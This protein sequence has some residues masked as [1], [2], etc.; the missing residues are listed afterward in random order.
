MRTSDA[1]NL[2]PEEQRWLPWTGASGKLAMGWSCWL[3]RQR[4]DYYEHVFSQIAETRRAVLMEWAEQKWSFI[5]GVAQ[6]LVRQNST[7]A[8]HEMHKQR[9]R[10]REISELALINDQGV[11]LYS[12]HTARVGQH[13]LPPAAWQRGLRERFLHGPYHDPVTFQLGATTS[14]FHDAITLM[15][16]LPVTL[17]DGQQVAIL[18]RVPN[19]V[20]SDLIQREAGHVFEES[21]DNYLFMANSQFDPSIHS[22]VALSRSRFEDN[23]FSHGD[24]LKDGI[25]TGFGIVSVREHTEFE[26][27]FTDPAT[28]QLHPGV[29]ETLAAGENVYVKYPGYSDYRHIPVIGKGVTLQ[30]PGSPDRW[31]M[32]CEADLAEVY[33]RRSIRYH[34]S[35]R[36][37]LLAGIWWLM[38]VL[39]N[40]AA[41]PLLWSACVYGVGVFATLVVYH[42]W[43]AHPLAERLHGMADLV[44]GLADGGGNL[45]QRLSV[46]DMARDETGDLAR[47]LN[48]F[49][50]SLDRMVSNVSHLSQASGVASEQLLKENQQAEQRI[51]GV[52]QS[53]QTMLNGAQQQQQDIQQAS[54]TA[55]NLRQ[56]MDDVMTRAQQ[57]LTRVSNET[58]SIRS[59]IN[60]SSDSLQQANERTAEIA[61]MALVIKDIAAQ[62]NLLALNA[63]IEA[64]RAGDSGRGFAVVAS[65]V[66]NLASRTAQATQEID[67]GLSRVQEETE[68]AVSTME[69]GM[70][71]MEQR[72]QQAQAAASDHST[73]NDMV[74]NLFR[75]MAD[76]E[77]AN[78]QQSAQ[79]QEVAEGADSMQDT[80]A[81][82]IVSADTTH[83]NASKLQA[84]TRQFQLSKQY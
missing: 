22:G 74:A 64:A 50:D 19:D 44:R 18:A 47:W 54:L 48:S 20:M 32:M 70:S 58:Q 6:Q 4:Y 26:I 3:N 62:T 38:G 77:N 25:D 35:S 31:G 8:L 27:R 15:F 14:R 37:A 71:E 68:R 57:Q 28:G 59:V 10:L 56:Q 40:S 67:N 17:A 11:V 2:T 46:K 66:R 24:N 41:L 82:L 39:L 83:L 49:I 29:R 23:T 72:L 84:L 1:M 81:G 36:L 30:L 33:Q 45:A 55:M 43:V 61:R 16:Y 12:N 52:L 53:I 21:G 7:Q 65:E 42:S 13:D 75:I 60:R 34:L 51:G 76:I 63:A 78:Q 9:D 5:E 80:I 73:L 79:T 69:S